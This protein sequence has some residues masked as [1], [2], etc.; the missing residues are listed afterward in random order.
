MTD[1]RFGSRS[2]GRA[3]TV[4]LILTFESRDHVEEDNESG[5][6]SPL[7]CSVDLQIASTRLCRFFGRKAIPG[8][9]PF[10]HR[11]PSGMRDMTPPHA[12]SPAPS[13]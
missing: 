8:I 3:S 6:Q 2:C 10:D 11:G 7:V 5:S 4:R 1:P 13:P 9:Q 12:F